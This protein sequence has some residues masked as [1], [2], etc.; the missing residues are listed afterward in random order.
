MT[1]FIKVM[2]GETWVRTLGDDKWTGVTDIVVDPRNSDLIYAATW[3]RHRKVAA[4]MGGGPGSGIHISEDGG[5][6]WVKLEKGIPKSNLGKIGLA[7]SP[8]N[9]DIVYAAIELDR[10]TG[11]VFRSEN[12]GASWKKM[13]EAGAPIVY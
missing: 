1:V 4:Y 6:T 12:R 8:Q 9:P 10:R 5:D 2:M 7:I 3:Q 13:S 11:G